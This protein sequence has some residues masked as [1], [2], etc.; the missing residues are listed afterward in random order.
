MLI[1]L[2]TISMLASGCQT[3]S[4]P[5]IEIPDLSIARPERPILA[6]DYENVVGQ[7]IVY[8]NQMETYADTLEDYIVEIN[9]I[10]GQ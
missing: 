8:S 10:L 2:L 7:L 3:T 5:V 1:L 4:N 6:G 9:Y